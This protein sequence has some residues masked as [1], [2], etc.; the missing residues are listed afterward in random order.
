MFINI[1]LFAAMVL[2]INFDMFAATVLLIHFD[3]FAA[4][5]FRVVVF[6]M[7]IQRTVASLHVRMLYHPTIRGCIHPCLFVLLDVSF[8]HLTYV[9]S[10]GGVDG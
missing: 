9:H 2:L 7:V 6:L 10:Y 5:V 3:L 8:C 4:N 1:G